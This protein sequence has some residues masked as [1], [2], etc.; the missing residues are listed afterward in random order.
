MFVNPCLLRELYEVKECT[1]NKNR[2][3]VSWN[4]RITLVFGSSGSWVLIFDPAA[5][6]V[7]N[8]RISPHPLQKNVRI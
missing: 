4:T 5:L 6:M 1:L 3:I 7:W 8:F 2:A